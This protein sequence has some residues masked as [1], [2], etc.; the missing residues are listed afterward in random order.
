M[1]QVLTNPMVLQRL[2]GLVLFGGGIWAWFAFGGS[3][4]VVL[5]IL[6]PDLSMLG[7]LVN[8]RVGAAIYNLI[9]SYPLPALL[10][11]LGILTHTQALTGILL[12]AHIGMDRAAGYGLKLASGFQ[13]THL[14]RIGR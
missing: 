3:W 1:T 5:L 12:L 8:P 9:H 2:E 6:L 13:D 14:G 11:V 10:L 7:Y 4:W